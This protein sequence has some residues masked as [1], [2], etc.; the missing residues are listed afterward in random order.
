MASAVIIFCRE[1]RSQTPPGATYPD[2]ASANAALARML[3]H[4]GQLAGENG[5]RTFD[6]YTVTVP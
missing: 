5:K 2:A 4:S 3:K 6:T 1:T